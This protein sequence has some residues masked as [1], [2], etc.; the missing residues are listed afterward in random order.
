VTKAEQ[1]RQEWE[2]RIAYWCPS[3]SPALETHKCL[4]DWRRFR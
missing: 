1:R 3:L 4:L 2:K